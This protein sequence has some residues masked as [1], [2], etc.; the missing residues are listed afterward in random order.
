ML[1][2]PDPESNWEILA[3]SSVRDCRNAIM[4]SGRN[5]C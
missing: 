4:R 2:R 5:D 3:E 1:E